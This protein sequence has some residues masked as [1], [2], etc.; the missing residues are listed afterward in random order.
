MM[1]ASALAAVV[2]VVTVGLTP[3]Q[4]VEQSAQI[5]KAST[6]VIWVNV[7]VRAGSNAVPGLTTS[8]FELLD[9]GV[10]QN[11]EAVAIEEVPVDLTLVLDTS[12]STVSII[13]RF[14]TEAEQIAAMLRPRDRVRLVSV[15]TE[16]KE[17][18]PMTPA[19]ERLKVDALQAGGATPIHDALLLCLARA[20]VEGRRELV[21][22]FT[23]GFDTLSIVA[24]STLVE[25]ATRS[26]A[27]LHVVLAD[28]TGALPPTL[29]SLRAAAEVSGGELHGPGYGDA[30]EAF[31]R[32]FDDFRQSYVLRYTLTGVDRTG[33]HNVTVN[34]TKPVHKRYTLRARRGYFGG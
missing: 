12:G 19:G 15:S 25:A 3:T 7:A 32:V 20:P 9:N 23:D 29:R 11:I 2:A 27:V 13:N 8:D 1:R 31:K 16:I 28:P 22:A 33:W 34:L 26:D 18:F 6:D 17:V 24:P 10:R 14:K 30:A 21:V 5:F 4:S